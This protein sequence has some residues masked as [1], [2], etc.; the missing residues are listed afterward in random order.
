MIIVPG[1]NELTQDNALQLIH[2][3]FGKSAFSERSFQGFSFFEGEALGFFVEENCVVISSANSLLEA[4]ALRS[5]D[6]SDISD[7]KLFQLA[8][9]STASDCPLQF[10]FNL[11]EEEWLELDPDV[12]RGKKHLSGFA[13]MTND[14]G[15]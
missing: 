3:I 14:S 7:N 1:K 12:R 8:M 9:S 4:M 11:G 2:S 5:A 13:F 15:N 6:E 10:Y